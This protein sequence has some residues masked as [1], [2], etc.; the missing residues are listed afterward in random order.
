MHGAVGSGQSVAATLEH[1]I[2]KPA[3]SDIWLKEPIL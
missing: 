2:T 3:E 1:P